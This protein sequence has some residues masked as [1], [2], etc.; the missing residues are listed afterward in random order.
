MVAELLRTVDA[1]VL[2]APEPSTPFEEPPS[3]MVLMAPP[4]QWEKKSE[5]VVCMEQEV[6]PWHMCSAGAGGGVRAASSTSPPISV[7]LAWP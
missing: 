7:S 2:A 3:P 1:E 4:L 5:C 6:R